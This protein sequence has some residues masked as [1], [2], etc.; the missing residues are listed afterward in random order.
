MP[1]TERVIAI[2]P[3]ESAACHAGRKAKFRIF[4]ADLKGPAASRG[5]TESMPRRE[6]WRLLGRRDAIRLELR[7]VLGVTSVARDWMV[8]L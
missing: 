7:P 8:P 4:A 3:D 2:L 6:L 5:W 1:E